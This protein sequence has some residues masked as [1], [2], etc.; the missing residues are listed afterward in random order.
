MLRKVTLVIGFPGFGGNF[1][2]ELRMSVQLRPGFS[3]VVS[4]GYVPLSGG[5]ARHRAGQLSD[6]A[7]DNSG[8]KIGL[9]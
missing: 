6:Y 1:V 9:S 7:A 2:P 3:V 4:Q 5:V 8:S